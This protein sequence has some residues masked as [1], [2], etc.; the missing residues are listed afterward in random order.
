MQGSLVNFISYFSILALVVL[1]RRV[2]W[3]H[4][5]LSTPRLLL[6]D[7]NFDF[8]FSDRGFQ[9]HELLHIPFTILFLT[10]NILIVLVNVQSSIASIS[11]RLAETIAT[12]ICIL[13][14][15]SNRHSLFL[16]LAVAAQPEFL[17]FH[18]IAGSITVFEIGV[19]GVLK[20][21]RE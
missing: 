16:E 13:F 5:L 12:N 9:C 18:R 10:S 21:Q 14:L 17:W 11:S 2:L 20:A 3:V 6:H 4:R 15:L 1:E 8:G 19:L 7:F